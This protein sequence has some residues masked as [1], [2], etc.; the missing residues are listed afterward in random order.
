MI[1]GWW[2]AGLCRA[3]GGLVKFVEDFLHYFY[4]STYNLWYALELAISE[5]PNNYNDNTFIQRPRP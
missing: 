5:Q 3:A 2:V 4:I 1:D